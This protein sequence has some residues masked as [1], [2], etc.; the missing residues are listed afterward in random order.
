MHMKEKE[1]SYT[2]FIPSISINF[3]DVLKLKINVLKITFMIIVT[4]VYLKIL[5][6]W[7]GNT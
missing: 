5:L 2:Y 7:I 6:S 3:S 4:V 1:K